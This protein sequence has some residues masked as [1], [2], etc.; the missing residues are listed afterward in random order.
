MGALHVVVSGRPQVLGLRHHPV[1]S[2]W[3]D[4]RSC[5][6][7]PEPLDASEDLP[8]QIRCQGAVGEDKD[9]VIADGLEVPVAR[10]LLLRPV[11]RARRVLDQGHI[12]ASQSLI[13][14]LVREDIRLGCWPSVNG[15]TRAARSLR[16]SEGSVRA[17]SKDLP[18]AAGGSP[19]STSMTGKLSAIH[20]ASPPSSG[21]TRVMPCRWS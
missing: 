20:R 3:V 7:P 5:G 17:A 11:D 2:S 14:P 9:R 1:S 10:R 12:E 15:G 8:K 6:V 13:V 19:D 4:S 18:V 21:C 16:T